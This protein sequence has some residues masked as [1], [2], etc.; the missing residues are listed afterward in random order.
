MQIIQFTC[1]KLGK[2][3]KHLSRINKTKKFLIKLHTEYEFF[4]C[5][6]K[7]NNIN[8]VKKNMLSYSE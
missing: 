3:F 6:P 2:Q 8:Y 1:F 7:V 5:L 4:N